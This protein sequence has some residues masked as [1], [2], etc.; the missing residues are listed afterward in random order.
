MLVEQVATHF[1]KTP[2]QIEQESLRLYIE[3]K[4]RLVESELFSLVQ[5]YG[6][7]T[8]TELDKAVQAGQ[9]HEVDAF[10]DYFRFDYL[11]DER[12]K[13]RTLLEQL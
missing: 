1:D 2:Q 9:F 8:I 11:E 13:L 5:R 4:L 3:H 12:S 7:Q 6:V 10:E